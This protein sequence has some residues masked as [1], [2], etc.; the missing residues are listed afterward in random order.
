VTLRSRWIPRA[1]PYLVP[2]YAHRALG[3]LTP[4]AWF[5]KWKMFPR[6]VFVKIVFQKDQNKKNYT[7]FICLGPLIHLQK[8]GKKDPV[9][10]IANPHLKKI[11][12][13]ENTC[14]LVTK[15]SH[16]GRIDDDLTLRLLRSVACKAISNGRSIF[17]YP[18]H[19]LGPTQ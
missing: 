5:Q 4:C 11:T 1:P 19:Y 17:Q 7:F 10:Q 9:I 3:W 18:F 6:V 12:E 2:F 15:R 13:E 8:K 14:L 16:S